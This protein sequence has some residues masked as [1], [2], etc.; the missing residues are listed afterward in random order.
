MDRIWMYR[1]NRYH[2]NTTQQVTRYKTKALDRRYEEIWAKHAG[3]VD[4]LHDFQTKRF[5][6]RKSIDN[7][8]YE[9]KRCWANLAYQ[10]ITEAVLPIR[11]EIY[12]LSEF[13]GAR[14]EV[15]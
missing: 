3:L 14:L 10:H 13:L 15:G 7:I 9:S 11:S 5:E 2:G 6:N 8:N 1:N 4:R 12:T